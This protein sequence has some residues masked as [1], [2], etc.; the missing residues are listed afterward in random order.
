M[1]VYIDKHNFTFHGQVTY[2]TDFC[3]AEQRNVPFDDSSSTKKFELVK[4]T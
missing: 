4:V 3:R 1:T 2:S